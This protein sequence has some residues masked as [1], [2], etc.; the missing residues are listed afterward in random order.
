MK[1]THALALF[2][3][4]A[5]FGG[6]VLVGCS[7]DDNNNA[8]DAGPDVTATD[9]GPDVVS[10]DGG[11]DG[12]IT[13]PTLGTQ[14]DRFG[15]PAVNTAL[16]HTFDPNS[17]EAGASK[18]SYNAD[19]NSSGW[20]TKWAPEL[21]KNLA[22]LDALDSNCGNQLLADKDAGAGRYLP[23]AG[24]LADDRMWINTDSTTCTEYLAV[25]LNAL[26]ITNTDCGG[27][28]LDYDVIDTTYSA[29][30]LGAPTGF[31][32]TIDA[33]AKT[34]GTTFPYLAAPQ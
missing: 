29:T 23:L 20:A 18:D 9:S 8:S 11:G 24:V 7:G 21:A 16:N 6:S 22:I 31:G 19:N 33:P 34:K 1:T 10:S 3:L 17:A 4:T 26:G 28:K 5:A 15:R 27:R 13:P 12:G 2:A 32:D 30:A 14:I 25:E